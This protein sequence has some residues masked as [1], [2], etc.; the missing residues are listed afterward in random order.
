MVRK[1]LCVNRD[2]RLLDLLNF[3]IGGK[4]LLLI[5]LLYH[6]DIKRKIGKN[7]DGARLCRNFTYINFT[8]AKKTG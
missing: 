5:K 3:F 4:F 7:C 1:N 2:T 8:F 6:I